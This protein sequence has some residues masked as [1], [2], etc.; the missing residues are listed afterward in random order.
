MT[1]AKEKVMPRLYF[2]YG[3]MGSSKS[4]QALMCKFNYEQKGMKVLLVKPSLDN[5]DD[6]DTPKVRSRIG[7]VCECET[8]TPEGSFAKLYK[9]YSDKGE[10]DCI[11]V[12]EAQFCTT[13][14][15]DELKDLTE[16]VPVLC[17][18]LLADFKCR[19][20]E[21]SKRLVEL[22]DSLQEIK[23]VCRCGRKSTV[24][25]RFVNGKCVDD[26]P[27]VLIGGDESY[28]NMCYWCWKK[29]L[30]KSAKK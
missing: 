16:F 20:F 11:I 14:Q 12:D 19:L 9:E 15:V 26:G 28:E 21:G 23:S 1:E 17:Y 30:K 27:V 3:T 4:A 5:R 13:K 22:A 2:K 10:C 18:G 6:T 29:E 7:L 8:M 24:N 25:A